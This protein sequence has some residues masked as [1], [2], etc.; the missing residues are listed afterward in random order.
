MEET[1][2]TEKKPRKSD[3][4][5]VLLAQLII[6]IIAYM[7]MLI[8]C[9]GTNFK[10]GYFVDSPTL[11]GLFLIVG[12]GMTVMKVWKDF[13]K[14][15]S[16]GRKEYS[17]LELKNILEA[18]K[19][20]QKLVL[21]GGMFELYI[22]LIYTLTRLDDFSTMGLSLWIAILPGF[23]IVI[24]EFFLLPLFINTQKTINEEMAFD[25]KE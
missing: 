6:L 1:V 2:K 16:V 13:G 19:V 20:F 23:Y 10:M 18:V 11:I 5:L 12:L 22:G 8:S 21:L 17:L 14:A 24:T 25:E 15:F 4:R 9:L 3:I 7:W